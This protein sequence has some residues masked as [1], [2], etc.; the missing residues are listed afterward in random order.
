MPFPTLLS[1][2]AVLA[3]CSSTSGASATSS[4]G[5]ATSTVESR[6]RRQVE[7]IYAVLLP[8]GALIFDGQEPASTHC[9]ALTPSACHTEALAAWAAD[10]GP[11]S[12]RL[13]LAML[14]Q[15]CLQGF[16]PSCAEIHGPRALDGRA[17]EYTRTARERS[18]Q[19]RVR[20]LC[21][22]PA[23]A[24]LPSHCRLVESIPELDASVLDFLSTT[25]FLPVT[26]FGRPLQAD[27]LFS[28]SFRVS[29]S[30]AR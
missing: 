8:D 22:L 24:G 23:E 4:A 30:V 13:A 14:H 1:L 17:P 16:E 11:D 6:S 10:G 18:V 28:F 27:Y 7:A 15:A 20:M 5:G 12:E 9:A 3:R 2:V 21:R 26:F 29:T 19:G 25:H